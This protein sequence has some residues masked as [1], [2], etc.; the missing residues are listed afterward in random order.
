[1]SP[2]RA[3]TAACGPCVVLAV[4][5]VVLSLLGGCEDLRQFR[6]APGDL[7]SGEVVGS[8]TDPAGASFIRQ[9]FASHTKLELSFDP[10]LATLPVSDD[11]GAAH[12]RRGPG[13]LNTYACP[14]GLTQ[15]AS[16]L[17]TAGPFNHSQLLPVENLVHDSLSQYTF[18][19]GGR[20]RNYIFGTRFQSKA[21][22]ATVSRYAMIFISLMESGKIEVRAM[23]PNV[24]GSD[25]ETELLPALFGV[26]VLERHRT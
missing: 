24:L 15:C 26:F 4:L 6:S 20:I 12:S 13:E 18:P 19:G 23:A 9:G 11:A 14:A 17:R 1:M 5:L 16:A 21:A 3:S 7:F 2:V 22:G 8:D 10:A 25:A